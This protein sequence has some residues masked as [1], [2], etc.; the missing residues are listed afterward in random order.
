MCV[1]ACSPT[2]PSASGQAALV[3][4]ALGRATMTAMQVGAFPAGAPKL[5][6]DAP[7]ISPSGVALAG[8]PFGRATCP[9]GGTVEIRYARDSAFSDAAIDA[10]ALTAVYRA[11]GA[12]GGGSLAQVHGE[13][14][15]TGTYTGSADSSV[16]LSGTVATSH[17]DCVVDA[18]LGS[19]GGFKGSVCGVYAEVSPSAAHE[20]VGVYALHFLDGQLLPVVRVEEPCPGF[21]DS[22]TLALL[23]DGTYS[24]LLV[25][26]VECHDG[27]GTEHTSGESGRWS[28]LVGGT[29][30]F[31]RSPASSVS[32]GLSVASWTNPTVRVLMDVPSFTPGVAPTRMLAVF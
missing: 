11:C 23:P 15:L 26:H 17:G 24:L 5:S 4:E 13:L 19:A 7:L 8:Q 32:H 25:S 9:G 16:R 29:V 20:A 30:V 12:S 31:E 28:E 1:S 22:G 3:A 21:I 27:T 2:A 6:P 18:V 14:E 10:S